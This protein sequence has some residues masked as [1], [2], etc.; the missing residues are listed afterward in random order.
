MI[1]DQEVIKIGEKAL[2]YNT[3]LFFT[4]GFQFTFATLYLSMGKAFIGGIL[5]IGRQGLF[6][7]PSIIILNNILGLKGI[8]LAQP[9]ADIISIFVTICVVIYFKK[10]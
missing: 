6:F 4:F 5:N 10:L 3:I 9:V 1:K 7:I 8:M 2:R